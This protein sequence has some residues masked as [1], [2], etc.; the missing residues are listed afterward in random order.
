MS[1]GGKNV[2]RLL[3]WKRRDCV[4]K[5]HYAREDEILLHSNIK[6][7]VKCDSRVAVQAASLGFV[8]LGVA[9][10]CSAYCATGDSQSFLFLSLSL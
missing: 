4:L 9:Q 7:A 8:G 3:C 5:G 1:R 6:L 10:L 2:I